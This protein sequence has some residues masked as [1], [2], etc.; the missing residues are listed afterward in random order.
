MVEGRGE[1][2][3]TG[4]LLRFLSDLSDFSEHFQHTS[5]I[6]IHESKRFAGKFSSLGTLNPMKSLLESHVL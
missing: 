5:S 3:S 6:I 1:Q 2:G 4:P